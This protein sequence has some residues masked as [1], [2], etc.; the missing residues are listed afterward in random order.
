MSSTAQ[1]ESVRK[2]YFL[3]TTYYT[4]IKRILLL[5]TVLGV[6]LLAQPSIYAQEKKAK[7]SP[8]PAAATTETPAKKSTSKSKK[9]AKKPA[10]KAASP[11]P[12]AQ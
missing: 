1:F 3:V 5:A 10:K 7:A 6:G 2:Q 11:A 9:A 8:S 12:A 4:M